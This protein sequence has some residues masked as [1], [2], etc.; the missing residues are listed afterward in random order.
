M[1]SSSQIPTLESFSPEKE[2]IQPLSK[3]RSANQLSQLYATS[4]PTA[5]ANK[6]A[7][8]RAK[9][10]H[11]INNQPDDV[12]D[13]LDIHHRYVAWIQSTH[14]TG[15]SPELM[16][17]VERAVRAYRK[18]GRYKNDIRF[19][20]LWIITAKQAQ[21]PRAVFKYMAVNEIG[22]QLASYYE[23]Y[24][25]LLETLSKW[26]D[27]DEVY[28]LGLARK[29]E[30][31]QRLERKY[32][33]F[34]ERWR[35]G[36]ERGVFVDSSSSSSSSSSGSQ[37][38]V[39]SNG[40][41]R[42]LQLREGS[43][44]TLPQNSSIMPPPPPP[45]VMRRNDN[46]PTSKQSDR[47]S[48]LK[49]ADPPVAVVP[50][51]SS[52]NPWSEYP[53]NKTLRK[54][55]EPQATSWKG[56]ILPQQGVNANASS[57]NGW[58]DVKEKIEVFKDDDEKV[59][60]IAAA[61]PSYGVL[62]PKDALA[63]GSTLSAVVATHE[64]LAALDV[65]AST[66][67]PAPTPSMPRAALAL[68][69]ETP[70]P[71]GTNTLPQ[72]VTSD[73]SST[74]PHSPSKLAQTPFGS[75]HQDT[76]K[77]PKL[78]ENHIANLDDPLTFEERR[79][80]L[81]KYRY[82]PPPTSSSPAPP[83]PVIEDDQTKI[84]SYDITTTLP[85]KPFSAPSPTINTKEAMADVLNMFRQ[86]LNEE[87][88]IADQPPD[89]TISAK[90]FK[91]EIVSAASLGVFRDGEDN[92]DGSPSTKD[93]DN[94]KWIIRSDNDENAGT[95]TAALRPAD[96]SKSKALGSKH[97]LSAKSVESASEAM[98]PVRRQSP[99]FD[100]AADNPFQERVTSPVDG[101]DEQENAP[102]PDS[103]GSNIKKRR[104]LA[105]VLV[106]PPS[107]EFHE[108]PVAEDSTTL[109]I[110][111]PQP[112]HRPMFSSTPATFLRRPG[113]ILGR[114][115]DIMT[116]ITDVPEEDT[117]IT[118]DKTGPGFPEERTRSYRSLDSHSASSNT[119]GMGNHTFDSRRPTVLSAITPGCKEVSSDT[120]SQTIGGLSTISRAEVDLDFD[121]DDDAYLDHTGTIHDDTMVR[122]LANKSA[123]AGGLVAIYEDDDENEEEEEE[124]EED[125]EKQLESEDEEVED[126]PN[127]GL[128]LVRPPT[129]IK[130]KTPRVR[131]IVYPDL[132]NPCDMV[133]AETT[134]RMLACVSQPV[135]SMPQ[136]HDCRGEEGHKAIRVIL[137]AALGGKPQQSTS[138][139]SKS[140]S[141]IKSRTDPRDRDG[142]GDCTFTLSDVG[143]YVGTKK[144][145]EGGHGS[146][147]MC[148]KVL[149]DA[150]DASEEGQIV[151]VK[152]QTPANVWEF[153]ILHTLR[154]RLSP[155]I[156]D[157]I[158]MP[159]SLHL[160]PDESVLC[161]R[162]ESGTLL[163]VVNASKRDG[164]GTDA[165]LDEL[166]VGF[167]TI[168][169]LRTI[170]A[171]HAVGI[172]HNDIKADNVLIRVPSSNSPSSTAVDWD[173]RYRADG[174]GGWSAHDT[175][176]NMGRKIGDSSYHSWEGRA[177][178]GWRYEGDW[179][180]IASVIH[181]MLFGRYMEVVEE[182]GPS[183]E[184]Q[185]H[186][187]QEWHEDESSIVPG[188]PN[189]FDELDGSEENED[190]N[191]G[192]KRPRIRITSAMKRYWQGQLWRRL[193]AVLLNSGAYNEIVS[194]VDVTFDLGA[195][196]G[197]TTEG[198]KQLESEFPV[199]KVIRKLRHEVEKWVADN[200]Y[201]GGLR[202][203]LKRAESRLKP[204][205]DQ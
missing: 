98:Q 161:L 144:L 64:M 157:S 26:N 60:R 51:A 95:S 195:D 90:V 10:E 15:H 88:D 154:D 148:K 112:S 56:Q 3:G 78:V 18:D 204:S 44:H 125:E 164:F 49:H 7:E 62:K 114:Q 102:S 94:G 110:K 48:V 142:S 201:R 197:S 97:P 32:R 39:P 170:E 19:F 111:R 130:S 180:G 171:V 86:P 119:D 149:I 129:P 13:P 178:V 176:S 181:V 132:P 118:E 192:L 66:R 71:L 69:S 136:F 91:R 87:D 202:G 37:D 122:R 165:C 123:A 6:L 9:F 191:N 55:N 107:E 27:A 200:S 28:K 41:R 35:K 45:S 29:A 103:V 92:A 57:A 177:G 34:D 67:N 65:T 168:E 146:V 23:E 109:A 77:K 17:A 174:S 137:S 194:R 182:E 167:W 145:G 131:S 14:T 117:T 22:T 190:G 89:E 143:T 153:Y 72:S 198:M 183:D 85:R 16:K 40:S 46:F 135:E 76:A 74:Q 75:Q 80:M 104:P 50:A 193:F 140:Y 120:L 141:T 12:D 124:R 70:G 105:P 58:K 128:V 199:V 186:A 196:K 126:E 205:N 166:L 158:V 185:V 47:V 21:D 173:A 81:P 36:V 138:K 163:D 156:L 59:I 20:K 8:E 162:Y 42:A 113:T 179:Y 1:D 31:L 61:S 79:A 121:D 84:I 33:Q 43:A 83:S 147:Y 139:I 96:G 150:D 172:I 203:A 2:N 38:D 11:A 155:S 133:S 63:S 189:P 115:F 82:R 106:V 175:K 53:N 101:A 160:Y 151:A 99:F 108:I 152:I 54:E 100:N 24:A 169:L 4:D 68:V 30:P 73:W 116:P 134:T 127:E 93:M 188:L 159:L 5:L 25:D 184:S 52:S 187:H